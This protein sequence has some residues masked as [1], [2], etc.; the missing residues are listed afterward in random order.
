MQYLFKIIIFF[1]LIFFT[2]GCG[3]SRSKVTSSDIYV[4]YNQVGYLTDG[5]KNI[6]II[7][8]KDL[9]KSKVTI[10]N[11]KNEVVK[12]FV[13]GKSIDKWGK[14]NY[15]YKLDINNISQEEIYN[16]LINDKIYAS[17]EVS[18]KQ[19]SSIRDSVLAFFK[20]Q[21]CGY[22]NPS[23]HDVCHIADATEIYDVQNNKLST[24]ADLTGGWHDAGDYIKFINTTAFTTYMLLFSYEFDPVRY[25]QDFNYNQIPDVL[26][27]AKVGLDWLLKC[28]L[29]EG[30]LVNIVQNLQDHDQGWRLPENDKLKFNRPAYLS[31]GKNTIG[32]YVATLSLAYRIWKDKINYPEYQDK[33]L[34]TAIEVFSYY[35]KVPD[36]DDNPTKMY[37][38]NKYTGK[39]ALGALEL[40][41]STKN[42]NYLTLAKQLADNTP[43]DYWWSWGDVSTLLFYKIFPYD[44]KHITKIESNLRHFTNYYQKNLFN[45]ATDYSWGTT[46][47]LLGVSLNAILYKHLTKNNLYDSIS[48]AQLN[49]ILGQNNWGISFIYGFGK[50]YVKNLHSQIAFFNDGKLYGAVTAG[51]VPRDIYST[52]KIKYE[53]DDY[54]KDFHSE[55][56]IYVDDRFDYLTNE[57]TIVTNATA[58]FVFGFYAK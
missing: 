6:I 20:S 12:V 52:Y 3:Q 38:D 22:T 29:G 9:S 25:G 26:E 50:N 41:N 17:F 5:Y 33:L 32:M 11:S 19:Y 57:P 18:N 56:A 45:N 47:A 21:R 1:V 36:I 58:Y 35:D 34:K 37:I 2:I 42:E 46:H 4:R 39:L 10:I 55:R 48:T 44:S 54:L 16:V 49:Y 8:K 7:S 43:A 40:Y 13:L 15:N 31:M 30:K 23:N 14:F 27:E 24:S 28:Y 51:P 53:K